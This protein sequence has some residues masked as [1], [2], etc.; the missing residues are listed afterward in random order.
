MVFFCLKHSHGK[1]CTVD[2][3]PFIY[4]KEDL[5]S[6]SEDRTEYAWKTEECVSWDWTEEVWSQ[7][8][9]QC[10]QRIKGVTIVPAFQ[11]KP[12]GYQA[13]ISTICSKVTCI[14]ATP[15]HGMTDILLIGEKSLGLVRVQEMTKVCSVEV[16]TVKDGTCAVTVAGKVKVWPEKLGE[17]LASMYFFGTLNYLN[18]LLN[19]PDQ[20]SFETYGLLAIRSIGCIVIQLAVD[21]TG[22]HVRLIHE[23]GQFS[24]GSALEFVVA[25]VK[26]TCVGKSTLQSC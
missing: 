25:K 6:V 16:G 12:K 11:W 19:M 7:R 13:D 22:C 4:A 3:K 14:N 2:I 24:L 8:L 23:G 15:F 26:K 1:A 5:K 20:I 10:I 21:H 18:N 9:Y 17:L